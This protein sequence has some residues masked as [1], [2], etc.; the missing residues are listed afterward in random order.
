MENE[1]RLNIKLPADLLA[2]VKLIAEE[3]DLTVSTLV[4]NLLLHYAAANR[5]DTFGT[6]NSI[7][8]YQDV[9]KRKR[10]L[11]EEIKRTHT[12]FN[13]AKSRFS[14]FKKESILV[15][16]ARAD[17]KSAIQDYNNFCAKYKTQEEK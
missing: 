4:R 17:W 7:Y 12:N 1:A 8:I 13:E 15:A 16:N 9:A 10:E 14:N 6:D 11:R 5:S 3:K 2:E